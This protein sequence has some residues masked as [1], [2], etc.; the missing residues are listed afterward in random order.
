MVKK[1]CKLREQR[2][3]DHSKV[4]QPTNSLWPTSQHRSWWSS[5]S[6]ERR[7]SWRRDPW[8]FPWM[9]SVGIDGSRYESL[10]DEEDEK[11]LWYQTRYRTEP[12]SS[13]QRWLAGQCLVQCPPLGFPAPSGRLLPRS[14]PLHVA[15]TRHNT[16]S[17]DW[18]D[19]YIEWLTSKIVSSQKLMNCSSFSLSSV[20]FT[21]KCRKAFFDSYNRISKGCQR[22]TIGRNE[23]WYAVY[24]T[25]PCSI[26]LFRSK[27]VQCN[28]RLP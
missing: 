24:S 23:L 22:E 19:P 20:S 1:T 10:K 13:V 3:D 28:Q 8:S 26:Q 16:R 18:R 15:S 25:V 7:W 4:M 21:T 2:K 12:I 27:H 9:S 11:L 6:E 5:V 17:S 14:V